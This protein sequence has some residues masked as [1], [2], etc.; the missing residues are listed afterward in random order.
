MIRGNL[1]LFVDDNS[2]DGQLGVL[3]PR[4]AERRDQSLKRRHSVRTWTRERS[5]V[6]LQPSG[7]R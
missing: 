2:R 3:P 1:C 5:G 6:L 7:S 4:L